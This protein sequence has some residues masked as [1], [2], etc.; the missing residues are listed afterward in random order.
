[1]LIVDI[2]CVMMIEQFNLIS[3]KNIS[4]KFM[5]IEENN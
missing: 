1:M 5:K 3:M 2:L 4:I